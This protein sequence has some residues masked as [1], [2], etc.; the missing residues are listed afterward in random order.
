ME[1]YKDSITGKLDYVY[2]LA[3]AVQVGKTDTPNWTQVT[4][5]S[6][7]NVFGEAMWV[8]TMMCMRMK[9]FDFVP[10]TKEIYVIIST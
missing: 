3:L 6:N 8:E 2:P 7:S 1:Q 9:K 5:G 4:R 10:H